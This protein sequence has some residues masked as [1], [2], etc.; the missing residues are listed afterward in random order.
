MLASNGGM[1][2]GMVSESPGQLEACDVGRC[3]CREEGMW[4]DEEEW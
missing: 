4:E 3:G 2:R 1:T